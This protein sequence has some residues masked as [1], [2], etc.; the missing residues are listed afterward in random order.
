MECRRCRAARLTCHRLRCIMLELFT[1]KPVFQGNDE[2]HQLDVIFKILGTPTAERWPRVTELPW[3]ELVKPKEAIPN[4]FRTLFQKCVRCGAISRAVGSDVVF[5]CC[6]GG[7][8]L[9]ASIWRSSCSSMIRRGGSARCRRWRRR[10]LVRKTRRRCCRLR[11]SFLIR[12]ADVFTHLC[13]RLAKLEGE[14]HELETKR[15]RAKKKRRT[16]GHA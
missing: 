3:Y 11:R 13:V 16:E 4:H 2:I 9:R 10:T 1:K 15:E 5:C 8:R 7:C 14:W 12:I 6:A